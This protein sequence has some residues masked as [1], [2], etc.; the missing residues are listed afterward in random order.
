VW[1]D[2]STASNN[3]RSWFNIEETPAM[4]LKRVDILSAGKVMGVMYAILGFIGAGIFFVISMLGFSLAP[5][6][7]AAMP[8]AMVAVACVLVPVL[9]GV[10]G[11]IGGLLMALIYN[12]VASLVGGLELEFETTPGYR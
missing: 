4:I 11:F 10:L 1:H 12:V 5:K 3:G 7:G 8:M 2:S 6:E 9:Y